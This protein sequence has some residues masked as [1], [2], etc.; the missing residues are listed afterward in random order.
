MPQ[1][2]YLSGKKNVLVTG[3]AGFIGSHLCDELVKSSN[4]I[5]VDNYLTGSES[6]IDHLLQLPNFEFIRHD[7]IEPLDLSQSRE[8]QK[9]KVEFQGLQE[10][11]HLACPTSPKEYTKYP[12]ETLLAN[13]YATK[14]VLD[15]AKTYQTTFLLGSSSSIYGE[16]SDENNLKMSEDYWGF[17][18]NLDDKSCYDEGKRFAESLTYHYGKQY[19]L[20]V[21]IARIW[22]TYGPR[23]KMFD[24]R[25]IPDLISQAISNQDLK[26][27]GDVSKINS[28]C[29]ISDLIV[30]LIK[31]MENSYMGV[32][33]L[34]NPEGHKLQEVAQKI[35]EL[36]G[37]QAKL[38]ID[39]SAEF[40][41]SI[42]QS[43]PDITKA[44]GKIN[45]VPVVALADGLQETIKSMKLNQF[46]APSFNELTGVGVEEKSI[47]DDTSNNE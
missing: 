9:F 3:G 27:Y 41:Y 45:W 29:Y 35:I 10:I 25:M 28:F 15:I 32:L 37:A 43:L 12:I 34:G 2:E 22:N 8:A 30:G 19:N 1:V 21:K 20:K 13:A 16:T 38:Q 33:N 7:L 42:K 18:N 5:C 4:V 31:F 11:Y 26:I 36:I 6:N 40:N 23:M 17:I 44:K 46:K 39:K 14:N 47:N 24:G